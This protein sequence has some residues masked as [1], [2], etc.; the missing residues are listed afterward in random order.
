MAERTIT[1]ILEA[2]ARI[3]TNVKTIAKNGADHEARIRELEQKNG[4]RFDA[5]V[6]AAISAAVVG[7]IGYAIGK[8]F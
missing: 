6:L 4:K 3:E 7:V 1:E 5:L 8:L 2:L